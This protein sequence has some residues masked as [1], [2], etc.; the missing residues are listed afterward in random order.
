M[1]VS[2]LIR[3]EYLDMALEATT[4]DKIK[5][6]L[7]SSFDRYEI[8]NSLLYGLIT[9]AGRE[10][11]YLLNRDVSAGWMTRSNTIH[12]IDNIKKTD[13]VRDDVLREDISVKLE[14][15][16]GGSRTVELL[17]SSFEE[18]TQNGHGEN[19]S[20]QYIHAILACAALHDSFGCS[21]IGSSVDD[22]KLIL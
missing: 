21:R 16:K 3:N 2:S 14:G 13:I 9:L 20:K 8:W 11:K 4:W 17:Y 19:I 10:S 1:N 22:F 7:N 5:G 18:E 12:L 6:L 15:T